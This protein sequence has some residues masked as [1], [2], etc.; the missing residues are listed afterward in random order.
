M[1]PLAR[2]CQVISLSENVS[3]NIHTAHNFLYLST[4]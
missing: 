2:H 3:M 4:H 1:L